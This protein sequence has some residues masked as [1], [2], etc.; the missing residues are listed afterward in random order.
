[1]GIRQYNLDE[2]EEDFYA[3]FHES[4]DK[5]IGSRC[6]FVVHSGDLFDEPRP[7]VRAMVEARDA[8]D[9]LLEAEIPIFAIAGN[10]DIL[11]RKGAVPPHALYKKLEMLTPKNPTREFE[12]VLICGL[13]YHSK[14]HSNALK[15]KL[16]E[17]KKE[18]KKYDKSIL[19]LHQG[20]DKY[21]GL[22]YELKIG[23]VPHG[24][25]YYALGHIHKR[26]EDDFGGGKLVYPGSTEIWRID[27]LGD[28][29][30]NGKGFVV[31]DASNF[32]P[33]RINL[34][35]TRQFL[36]IEID[37]TTEF[38]FEAVKKAVGDS[39]PVMNVKIGSDL[40]Y[41]DIYNR[42]KE[43]EGEVLRLVVKKGATKKE[44]EEFL[45]KTVNIQEIM[46]EVME[47]YTEK[48][49]RFAFYLFELLK[50]RK[51]EEAQNI[52]NDFFGSWHSR[53][54]E[55][56]S[57]KSKSTVKSNSGTSQSSLGVFK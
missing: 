10:H 28:Y 17:L 30:K 8:I 38:D 45:S 29:K 43:L 50:E 46:A 31:V 2:R 21:F 14:V 52:A 56:K 1:M 15:E 7:Q 16:K 47:G 37:S 6:D 24:F 53:K 19:A 36:N 51:V 32:E 20:I 23:D 22:E 57:T 4:V 44:K 26:I 3:A 35:G 13:P 9:R 39:K 54:K 41:L 55:V 34:E 5:I 27:E 33:E 42:L 49:K 12:G 18:A 25:D 40:E 48:E 11:M